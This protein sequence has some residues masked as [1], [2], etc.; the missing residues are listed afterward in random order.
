MRIVES[1]RVLSLPLSVTFSSFEK[2]RDDV[3]TLGDLPVGL[4]VCIVFSFLDRN[5]LGVNEVG[6]D[7]S[8]KCNGIEGDRSPSDASSLPDTIV[9]EAKPF[10]LC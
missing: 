7:E 6:R 1:L 4:H 10:E 2:D 3:D 8:F 5:L 9:K